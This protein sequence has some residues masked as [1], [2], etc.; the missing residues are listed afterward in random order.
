MSKVQI[1]WMIGRLQTKPLGEQWCK[2][3]ENSLK[4]EI[5][6]FEIPERSRVKDTKKLEQIKVN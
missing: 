2:S 5:I 4:A 6:S 3:R 1:A